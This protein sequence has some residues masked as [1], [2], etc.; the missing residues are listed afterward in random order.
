MA[1]SSSN[2]SGEAN[3]VEPRE[4]VPVPEAR[5]RSIGWITSFVITILLLRALGWGIENLD[6]L[7]DP[8][9]RTHAFVVAGV[10]LFMLLP[11]LLRG[12]LFAAFVALIFSLVVNWPRGAETFSVSKVAG[13]FMKALVGFG[14]VR[15]VGKLVETIGA[16]QYQI[17]LDAV[18]KNYDSTEI[19]SLA[20]QLTRGC[21]GADQACVA[22][23]IV[24]YVTHNYEYRS[25]PV[26][27]LGESDYVRSPQ[28]TVKLKAGDC[29]DLTVLTS[30]LLIHVGVPSY[31]VFEKGHVYPLACLSEPMPARKTDISMFSR[32]FWG[33]PVQSIVSGEV[34]APLFRQIDG[35]YCYA[36]EPTAAG[37]ELAV[38]KDRS[39]VLAVYD[40]L[41]RKRIP[42]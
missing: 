37:T 8:Q 6:N 29:D 14:P 3:S 12:F 30:S 5:P 15:E 33:D 42:E 13:G 21:G 4:V 35:K 11:V 28:D 22:S 27:V 36:A 17:Y 10:L 23:R 38:D 2:S 19:N 40:P 20:L 9:Y 32:N 16:T 39:K 25:D 31:M 26:P 41:T 7:I 24:R 1:G 34:P 18:G